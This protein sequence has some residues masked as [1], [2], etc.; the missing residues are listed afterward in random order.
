MCLC[1]FDLSCVLYWCF[2][3]SFQPCLIHMRSGRFCVRENIKGKRQC[4]CFVLVKS[5]RV[6]GGII[7]TDAYV[8]TAVKYSVCQNISIIRIKYSLPLCPH[9]DARVCAHVCVC[10]IEDG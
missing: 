4:V 10:V 6:H 1:V 2:S 3:L 9:A 8:D 5:V 7:R